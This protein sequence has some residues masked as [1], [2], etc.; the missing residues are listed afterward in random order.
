MVQSRKD[1]G[2]SAQLTQFECI[3]N[4]HWQEKQDA[5]QLSIP[6]DIQ[7]LCFRISAKTL[8]LDH[9]NA[10]FEAVSSALPWIKD[11]PD[12]AIH[13]IY[14]PQSGN[15][16]KRE[17]D[18]PDQ[19]FF[20]SARSRLKIRLPVTRLPEAQILQNMNLDIEGH[21]LQVKNATTMPL[22]KTTTLFSRRIIIDKNENEEVFVDRVVKQL[23]DMGIQIRKV[24]CGRQYKLKL[25][26]EVLNVRS[27]ML[28][29]LEV[30]DAFH[31]QEKGLGQ[32]QLFG[33]GIFI[34]HKSISST[35]L[36]D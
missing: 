25:D 10:L 18:D 32:H 35:N 21:K 34:P 26:D 27:V 6:D 7:D 33:C 1:S 16:W 15:G 4:M 8:P 9:A 29:D 19:T 5:N 12:A 2:H 36:Q 13:S 23:T 22:I 30:E 11:Q 20:V 28:A 31:L 17:E 24:L 14:Y 3:G